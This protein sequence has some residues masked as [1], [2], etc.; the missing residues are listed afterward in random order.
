MGCKPS[1]REG[2]LPTRWVV[3][4]LV[5]RDSSQRDG[6]YTS[7][8]VSVD[9]SQPTP[10]YTEPQTLGKELTAAQRNFPQIT[11]EQIA[12][13][14]RTCSVGLYGP[15]AA[16]GGIAFL[17]IMFSFPKYYPELK[18][19]SIEIERSSDVSARTRAFLLKSA[20][21]LM[22]DHVHNCKLA[23]FESCC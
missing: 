7:R 15:W 9:D 4:P 17:R 16:R 18:P 5:G 14:S 2:F 22:R 21:E 6:L 11:F 12:V 1:R 3:N 19:P 10:H 20:R 23:A 13:Q 8:R